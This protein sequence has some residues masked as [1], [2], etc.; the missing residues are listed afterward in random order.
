MLQNINA[1]EVGTG[2]ATSIAG[3]VKIVKKQTNSQTEL[4]FGALPYRE[5][6]IMEA[7]ADPSS[8]I[9]YGWKPTFSLEKGI[10][11]TIASYS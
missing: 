9:E 10:S 2:T 11:E 5:N 7:K 8:L 3:F 6:E 4:K 1:F